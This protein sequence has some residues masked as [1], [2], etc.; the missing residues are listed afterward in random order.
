MK[1]VIAKKNGNQEDWAHTNDTVEE[2]LLQK[3]MNQPQGAF[4]PGPTT[5]LG[6][7]RILHDVNY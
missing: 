4:S 6:L 3:K 2:V 5:N 1:G 7:V